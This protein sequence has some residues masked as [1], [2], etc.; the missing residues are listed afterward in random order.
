LENFSRRER[1]KQVRESE[2]IAA[3]EKIFC[4]KGFDDASMDEIAREAQFTKR[5]LYQYFTNKEDLYFAVVQA[6]FSELTAYL[7][8]V[9]QQGLTGYQKIVE[10][11]HQ[12][13]QFF[14]EKPGMVRLISY[15]G[16]VK[17]STPED[18]QKRQ[19]FMQ[20]NNDLFQSSTRAIVEGQ[21]DGSV[22]ADVNAQMASF[23]LIFLMT[24]FFNQLAVSGNTFTGNFSLDIENFSQF[25][26]ELLCATLKNN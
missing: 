17:K 21:A 25:T 9:P 2:I 16:Y 10:S 22:R 3:A 20:L 12:F 5:T 15:I 18:S 14:K 11:C 19:E 4:Q 8:Q 24:G 23:S 13:Y 7:Q 6:G 26:M 1:E